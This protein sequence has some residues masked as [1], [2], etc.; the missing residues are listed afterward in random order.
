ME[1]ELIDLETS[2][3]IAHF[4]NAC[5]TTNNR[6]FSCAVDC[7]LE[8]S[9]RL[10]LPE[11]Q[12]K[13]SCNEL[14]DFFNLLIISGS[15]EIEPEN[16]NF[17]RYNA[18]RLLDEIRE[19][20]WSKIIE[21][22]GT[23]ANKDNDAQFSEI[24]SGNLFKILSKGEKEFFETNY[25][26]RGTCNSCGLEKENK[27]DI[28]VNF[29]SEN[30]YPELIE[31]RKDWPTCVATSLEPRTEIHCSTCVV[32]SPSQFKSVNFSCY[33]LLEFSRTFLTS[34]NTFREILINGN[35]YKLQALVQNK[36]A[37]FACAL[38]RD[39]LWIYIDDL[40]PEKIIYR[41][42]NEL[43][44]NQKEGWFFAVYQKFDSEIDFTVNALSLSNT[45]Y[46]TQLNPSKT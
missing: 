41:N 29:V 46:W 16:D 4:R 28:I 18:F 21:H 33:L 20:I 39:N 22:C 30:V 17:L 6:N 11:I 13:L 3:R 2:L 14:S 25:E 12:A 34:C 32:N 15:T 8:M 19:P 9:Y 40:Y 36:G 44:S 24:F 43:F 27:L 42:I 26:V 45:E 5:K 7:F 35:L 37:H 31:N 38:F 1:G 10:F 23:F